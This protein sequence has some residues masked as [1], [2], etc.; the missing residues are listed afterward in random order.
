[1]ERGRLEYRD[2]GKKSG[3]RS[4]VVSAILSPRSFPVPNWQSRAI[5]ASFRSAPLRIYKDVG[6]G[7]AYNHAR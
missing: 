2:E 7:D 3:L 6:T 4:D 1:M 5:A